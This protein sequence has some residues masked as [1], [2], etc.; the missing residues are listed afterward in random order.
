M[1][2]TRYVITQQ[3]VQY[4]PAAFGNA[5]FVKDIAWVNTPNEEIEGIGDAD[6]KAVALVDTCWRKAV[7]DNVTMTQPAKIELTNYA[8]PGNLFYES[9]SA[10]NGLAVFS[11]VYYKTWKAFIDGEEVPVLRA[12]YI[13]R[14]I[15]VPAGKHVIEFRCKDELLV[16]MQ[17][18]SIIASIVIVLTIIGLIVFSIIRRKRC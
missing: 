5:W 13:L 12:N 10:E 4:N 14:A 9:E 6:L 3:G 1:L 7:K 16:R 17:V 2:N 8:N 18:V 15:E 11:E